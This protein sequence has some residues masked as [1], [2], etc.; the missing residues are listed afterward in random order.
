MP[1]WRT[2]RGTL[3]GSSP[4]SWQTV[5][6]LVGYDS[7]R[8][9]SLSHAPPI[10]SF[11]DLGAN[12]G[13][14]SLALL[15]RWPEARGVGCEP[16]IECVRLAQQNFARNGVKTC[17]CLPVAVV[18]NL[19]PET[20]SFSYRPFLPNASSI[21]DS[22]SES[23]DVVKVPV[24]TIRFSELLDRIDGIVDLVKIDVEGAEYSI[25][26]ETPPEI[27]G[28][29]KLLAVEYHHV[30]GHSP[31]ELVEKLTAA[32]LP[33]VSHEPKSRIMWC[34]PWPAR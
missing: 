8:L 15:D 22:N 27:F 3:L 16:S 7:Y 30:P 5:I 34:G 28:R 10:R 33:L 14:F 11:V 29:I 12:I 17:E 9:A 25:I 20:V 4:Y 21:V 19:G 18:G 26:A 32:G 31:D 2:R 1:I 24:R 13:A 6:E 23:R